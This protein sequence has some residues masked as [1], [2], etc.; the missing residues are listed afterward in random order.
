MHNANFTQA[1][2][3]KTKLINCDLLEAHFAQTNLAG[4]DFTRVQNFTID[5]ENNS[6]K[7]AKFLAQDLEKLLYQYDIIVE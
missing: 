2:L 3:T 5:P 1:D 7:K 6:I 4:V